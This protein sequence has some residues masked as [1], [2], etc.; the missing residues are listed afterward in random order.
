MNLRRHWTLPLAFLLL[1]ISPNAASSGIDIAQLQSTQR[2][3]TW[4]GI[5]PDKWATLWLIKRHLSAEAYFLFSDPGAKLPENAALFGVPDA[6]LRRIKGE[7]MFRRLK[8]AMQL[9]SPALEALDQVVHDIEVNIWE[10]PVHPHSPWFESMFRQLQARYAR[11]QVPVDCYLALFDAA[12]ALLP[13]AD[14][15]PADYQQQLAMQ[16]HCQGLRTPQQR[17]VA[18]LDHLQTL[19]E[20]SLG[21]KVVFVDTREAQ[22]FDE[23]HLPGALQLRLRDVSSQAIQPLLDADLVIPYCVKDFRGFEVASAMQRL[24]LR[25]VATLSPNGLK[26]WLQAGLPVVRRGESSERQASAEL[27]RCAME[28]STCIKEKP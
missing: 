18:Q 10:K 28:P 24:G 22:E 12:V 8:G 19:R 21:I 5:E 16:A 23:V 27:M 26:G 4:R 20:I 9:H 11:D 13:R 2:F 25:Q 7:S 1:G 14:A 17:A 6:P 3:A 15:T